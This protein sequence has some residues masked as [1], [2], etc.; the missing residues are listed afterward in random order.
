MNSAKKAR[1]LIILATSL[2]AP[3]AVFEAYIV[4]KYGYAE[5][6]SYIFSIPLGVISYIAIQFTIG[7]AV[8]KGWMSCKMPN[9]YLLMAIW[10]VS[11]LT[12]WALPYFFPSKNIL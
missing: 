6:Y 4:L 11:V 9:N 8:V 12:L 2:V 5:P 3:F 7:Y 1:L 10:A